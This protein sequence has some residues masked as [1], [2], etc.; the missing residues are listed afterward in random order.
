[1]E[2][3]STPQAN[4]FDILNFKNGKVIERYSIPQRINDVIV[5]RVWSFRDI[6]EHTQ[7]QQSLK[8]EAEKT[9]AILHNASDGIHI[10]DY[11]GNILE[12]SDSFCSMLGYRR[13]EL[14]GMNVSEWDAEFIGEE[15]LNVVRRQFENPIR[16]EFE[17]RHRRKDGTIFNVEVSGL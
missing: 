9:L 6:T 4:S 13:D 1:M 8:R 16:S 15:L 11:D 14:I 5:G 3:Y 7:A 2:L 17:T 12:V 10:L